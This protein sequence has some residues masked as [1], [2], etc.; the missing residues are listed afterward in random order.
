MTAP[1]TKKPAIP[2]T[3][4]SIYSRLLKDYRK[5]MT[6]RHGTKVRVT[7]VRRLSAQWWHGT[8][9][10]GFGALLQ[11]EAEGYKPRTASLAIP[12]DYNRERAWIH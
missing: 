5:E 4:K 10:W 9:A 2:E 1:A 8:R 11:L 7:V 12:P 6:A 3:V